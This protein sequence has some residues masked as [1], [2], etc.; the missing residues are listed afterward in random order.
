M[1]T[2]SANGNAARWASE[3]GAGGYLAKPF[4]ADELIRLAER[5]C[6]AGLTETGAAAPRESTDRSS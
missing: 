4:E 5:L 3:V 1:W 6:A 2:N